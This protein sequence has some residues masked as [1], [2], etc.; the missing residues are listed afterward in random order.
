M[1]HYGMYAL[2]TG[3]LQYTANST[4]S[5]SAIGMHIRDVTADVS[6]YLPQAEGSYGKSNRQG[7]RIL[8]SNLTG[9]SLALI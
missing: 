8:G 2:V 3:V 7:K 9:H 1:M 4:Y 6:I 5:M